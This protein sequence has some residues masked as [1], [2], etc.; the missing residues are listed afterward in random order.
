M[1]TY[2][3]PQR[4][5]FFVFSCLQILGHTQPRASKTSP[6]METLHVHNEDGKEYV[7]RAC[8]ATWSVP[9]RP[10]Y[11]PVE[12][13][14]FPSSPWHLS[15]S[16]QSSPC[17]LHY[18]LSSV[19]AF[20]PPYPYLSLYTLCLTPLLLILVSSSLQTETFFFLIKT[21]MTLVG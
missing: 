9:P 12:C 16:C 7:C 3:H 5:M 15:P 6:C 17:L 19:I 10:T 11:L 13:V 21:R 1:H 18:L 4:L 14:P 8:F 2:T 20:C